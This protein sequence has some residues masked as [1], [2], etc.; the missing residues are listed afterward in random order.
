MPLTG[1]S[2]FEKIWHNRLI[3]SL[4]GGRALI[5]IDRHLLHDLSSPQAFSGLRAGGRRVRSPGLAMAVPDHI[6]STQVGRGDETV[7]GGQA[8]ITALRRNA[9]DFGIDL[10]DIGDERQGIVHVVAAEQGRVQPGLTVACGD[11]HTCTLGAFGAW[12]F[13]IG[14]S[15]V[16]HVLATQTLTIQKPKSSRLLVTGRLAPGVSAKDIALGVIARFGVNMAGGGVLEFAGDTISA[17]SMEERFTLCNMGIEASARSALIAPDEVTFDYLSRCPNRPRDFEAARV[18]WR[19]FRS[20]VD[21]LFDAEFSFDCTGLSPQV[22]WGTSP[23]QTIGID[24]R[25]PRAGESANERE[26]AAAER[27]LVYMGLEPG[28]SLA[29]LPV[30]TVFI[31]SCTNSRLSDLRA[32]A[33]IVQGRRVAPGVRAL[34]VPGSTAVRRAA[35][36][37]GLDRILMDAGFE[38]REAGCSMCVGMNADRVGSGERSVSTSNRNFEGRQGPGARTHLASP[39]TAAASALA[40]VIADPREYL[41]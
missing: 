40:G 14:T 18:V 25:V 22:S 8:M 17:L 24:E 33:G 38:W 35:E 9:A 21:A 4:G 11:S 6:V 15:D 27:A 7:E 19:Q 20:D 5:H 31:G 41:R 13:G 12:A 1:T 2:L 32:A 28:Q 37:E 29:G 16:E 10:F 26:T 3:T 23:G 34:V 39:V 30:G 36:A